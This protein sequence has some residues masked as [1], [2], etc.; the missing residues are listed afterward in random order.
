MRQMYDQFFESEQ[1]KRL[2]CA[3]TTFAIKVF[4]KCRL[5]VNVVYASAGTQLS[6]KEIRWDPDAIG[7]DSFQRWLQH[8]P[9]SLQVWA[10]EQNMHAVFRPFKPM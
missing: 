1:G 4:A 5:A 8:T 9:G 7:A 2:H 3:A 6:P 10:D